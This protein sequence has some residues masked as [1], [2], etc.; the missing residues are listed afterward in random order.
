MNIRDVDAKAGN[1]FAVNIDLKHGDFVHLFDLDILR[2]GNFSHY[3][4]NLVSFSL[5]FRKVL[6]KDLDANV[7]FH[8]RHEFRETH[9]DGLAEVV[10]LP[11]D[12]GDFGLQLGDQ[13]LFSHAAP[14][15]VAGL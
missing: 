13:L 4:R 6:A 12:F 14:P 10:A 7:G 15:R 11:R 9:L 1:G 5:E 2:A 3:G 8:A